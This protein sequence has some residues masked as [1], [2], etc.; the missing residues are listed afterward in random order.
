MKILISGLCGHMGAEVA[1]LVLAGCRGADPTGMT[2]VDMNACG[3][4]GCPAATSFAEA[5]SLGA[6]F[7]EADC[8]VDFSHHS[9]TPDLLAFAVANGI[10]AVIAT[11]GHTEEER[12]A[13]TAAAEKIPVFFAANFSLGV[14]L[15]IDT[16]R[17]VAAA[18]PDAEIEIIE[19]HHDRKLDAPS[20]TALA[21][22]N[23]L[24][25][26][27]PDATVV[28]GRTGYGKRTPDEIGI[29]AIRMGNIVG[30]HEVII[31][32]PNQTITLKHEAHD[33]ALFAEGAVAAAAFL[34]RQTTPRLYGM[35]D[36]VR[37]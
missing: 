17:Q 3:A 31:G 30:V 23:A 19:K 25:E 21:I 26:V 16:A 4:E 18:M 34:T 13:I 10:P 36:L 35:G 8:I 28:T 29:H 22:A 15:L 2:G 1:N 37:G 20:G 14:A 7:T 32:T 6:P 27:R 24:C 33:R 11:T 12:A 9:L 5:Q